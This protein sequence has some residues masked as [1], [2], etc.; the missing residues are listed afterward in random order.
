MHK[1]ICKKSIS[2]IYMFVLSILLIG[3]IVN[4]KTSILGAKKQVKLE[5]VGNANVAMNKGETKAL[6]FKSNVT[7]SE[8]DLKWSTDNGYIATVDSNGKVTAKDVGVV[9][10]TVKD[11]KS[12]ASLTYSIYI[13]DIRESV[14]NVG[15][16]ASASV[17]GLPWGGKWRSS[18][19]SIATV[20]DGEVTAKKKGK[21]KITYKAKGLEF[22]M[23]FVIDSVKNA[24]MSSYMRCLTEG[25]EM[26]DYL[27]EVKYF[28]FLD[29]N[30]DGVQELF[31][32]VGDDNKKNAAYGIIYYDPNCASERWLIGSFTCGK[33]YYLQSK[34]M[35]VS[36]DGGYFWATKLNKKVSGGVYSYPKKLPIGAKSISTKYKNNKANRENYCK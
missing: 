16:K 13:V 23:P 20:K 27:T 35:V 36:D 21:V 24:A 1:I 28:S 30:Q 26:T 3:I 25:V 10:I 5:A 19:K 9:E 4:D 7:E 2:F 33:L 15:S 34:K 8:L 29:V 22:K 12:K 32:N 6:K 31:V 17:E 14:I 11:R 18:D